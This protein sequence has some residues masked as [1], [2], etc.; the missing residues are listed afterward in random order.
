[1]KSIEFHLNRED[2]EKWIKHLTD[3]KLAGEIGKLRKKGLAGETLRSEL[4]GLV[5]KRVE[6]LEAASQ[7]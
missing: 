4:Y 5:K 2:F 7:G 1:M 6:E 3:L